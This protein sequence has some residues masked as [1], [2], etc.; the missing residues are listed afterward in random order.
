[1][2]DRNTVSEPDTETIYF[3]KTSKPHIQDISILGP[4]YLVEDAHMQ[5]LMMLRR[6][7]T[8]VG[9][10]M[11]HDLVND[12]G[13]ASME[14]LNAPL[15]DGNIMKLQLLRE[16][17]AEVARILPGEEWKILV[18][19]LIMTSDRSTEHPR[20]KKLKLRGTFTT[21]EEANMAAGKVL[22]DLK[23]KAGRGASMM[24]T[25]ETGLVLGMVT[26]PGTDD[27]K[28]VEIRYDDCSLRPMD[29]SGKP[30]WHEFSK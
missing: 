18:A 30:I 29:S 19:T 8:S 27:I 26:V 9:E 17:N 13:L 2:R 22:K 12:M 16:K 4:F 10:E 25:T 6:E 7:K 28:S 15:P 3:V 20:V 5:L 21:K 23:A 24:K 11:L 14:H 1:M